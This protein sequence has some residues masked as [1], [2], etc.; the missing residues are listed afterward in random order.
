MQGG[1]YILPKFSLW[2]KL[3]WNDAYDMSI[4]RREEAIGK[5]RLVGCKNALSSANGSNSEWS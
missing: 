4:A 1:G 2:H 3:S 5:A